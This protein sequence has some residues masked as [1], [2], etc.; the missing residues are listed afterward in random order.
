M[1]SENRSREPHGWLRLPV[2]VLFS[3]FVLGCGKGKPATIQGKVTFQGKPVQQGD[4]TFTRPGN[5]AQGGINQGVYV[6]KLSEKGLAPGEY[7]VVVSPLSKYE[8]VQVGE[9]TEVKLVLLG[10]QQIPGKYHSETTTPLQAKVTGENDTFD[11]E[12]QP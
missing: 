3:V 1:Q 9:R 10:A 8:N 4:I 12:L 6:L 5:V 7:R 2:A 11:F